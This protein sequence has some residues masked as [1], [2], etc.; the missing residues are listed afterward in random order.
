[1]LAERYGD[2]TLF[3]ITSDHGQGLNEHGFIGHGT[4][5]YDELVEVPF[6]VRLPGGGK[7]MGTGRYLSLT[8]VREFILSGLESGSFDTSMLYCKEA[9]AE[10]FGVPS[11]LT[12]SA[13][14]DKAKLKRA[15]KYTRRRFS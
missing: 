9:Y 6:M 7:P 4:F 10:S 2:N 15:E 11:N 14:I 5:L 1:D 12:M 8:R 3:I 13:S